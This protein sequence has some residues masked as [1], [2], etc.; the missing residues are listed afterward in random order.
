MA[1]AVRE[2]SRVECMPQYICLQF[3]INV[4]NRLE[5]EHTSS[6]PALLDVKRKQTNVGADIH[7][8]IVTAE[9]DAEAQVRFLLEYL[10]IYGRCLVAGD[11]SYLQTVWKAI[12]INGP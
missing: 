2:D 9:L 6:R 7:D 1:E 11:V 3:F 8:A 4:R 12:R 5:R 10:P